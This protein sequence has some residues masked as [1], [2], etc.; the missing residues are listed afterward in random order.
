VVLP[1]QLETHLNYYNVV[2]KPEPEWHYLV[3]KFNVPNLEERYERTSVVD[4]ALKA[5]LRALGPVL[6]RP[7]FIDGLLPFPPRKRSGRDCGFIVQRPGSSVHIDP[8]QR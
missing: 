1:E 7:V 3:E 6:S 4:R 2:S 5:R 8:A